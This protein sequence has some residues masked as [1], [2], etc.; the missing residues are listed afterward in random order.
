MR[1][2]FFIAGGIVLFVIFAA[3]A[4]ALF[5]NT[6][7]H[8]RITFALFVL[9]WFAIAAYNMWVGVQRAGY[10][11]A[12]ELPIFVGIFGIPAVFAAIASRRL[13]RVSGPGA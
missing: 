1:T 2:L 7:A 10:S 3:I 11:F 8:M 9:A 4:R 12:E 6:A 5:H 13:G